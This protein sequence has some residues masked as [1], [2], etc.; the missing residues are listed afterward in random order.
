[1]FGWRKKDDDANKRTEVRV[2]V[3]AAKV[4]V[5]RDECD[6]VEWSANGFSARPCPDWIGEGKEVTIEFRVTIDTGELEF[7]CKALI[8]RCHADKS[9]FAAMFVF[10]P[11]DAR[12]TIDRYFGVF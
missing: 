2:A 5:G 10:I 9:E 7:T 11:H 3:E 12:A 4:Q 8:V 6:V 1:M